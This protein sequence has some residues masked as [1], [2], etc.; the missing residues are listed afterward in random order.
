[1]T[2]QLFLL[3]TM[4]IRVGD[5]ILRPPTPSVGATLAILAHAGGRD[6]SLGELLEG[7]W[8]GN[9]PASA[10]S[11]LRNYVST[12]RRTL[13]A[14]GSAAAVT[15][16]PGGYRFDAAIE[17]DAHRMEQHLADALEHRHAQRVDRAR[18]S[19]DAALACWRGDALL[20]I[21]G[22]WAAAERR[23]LHA[24]RRTLREISA[25]IHLD[26]GDTRTASAELEALVTA[27]PHNERLRALLMTALHRSGRRAAA[28]EVF[29]ATRRL[30]IDEVGMEPGPALT[31][32]HRRLLTEDPRALP[33]LA[34]AARAVETF[35]PPALPEQ[36]AAARPEDSAPPVGPAA[37]TAGSVPFA[38][39]T[40]IGP[41]LVGRTTELEELRTAAARVADTGMSGWVLITGEAGSGKTALART[42]E[43]ALTRENWLPIRVACPEDEG[44]PPAW[45]WAAALRNLV[46]Q[47]HIPDPGVRPALD[48]LLAVD[49]PIWTHPDGS[50]A[51]AP[52][53]GPA[54]GREATR[55]DDPAAGRFRLH[56]A[57][58][59]YLTQ[60]ARQRPLLIV[61]EDRHRADEET[62]LLT[63][64]LAEQFAGVPVLFVMTARP[65]ERTGVGAAA[66]AR[67]ARLEP[68]R[69]QL[70]G[71]ADAE[72]DSLVRAVAGEGVRA[73]SIE[74]IAEK[75]AGNPFFVR[76]WA[77]LL[78]TEGDSAVRVR[79]PAGVREIVLRRI[80]VLPEPVG[81]VL[82]RAAVIGREADTEV[83]ADLIGD[84]DGETVL[85]VVEAGLR[86]GLLEEP[87]AG[88]I[89]FV[90]VLVR[91]ILYAEMAALRRSRLHARVAEIVERRLPGD[92]TALA[93]HYT[94]AATP[95][96][97]RKAAEYCCA[98]AESAEQRF[99]FADAARLWSQAVEAVRRTP[100]N[101]PE[102]AV[103]PVVRH[104]R[105]LAL[106]GRMEEARTHRG[107]ALARFESPLLRARVAAA[108]DIPLVWIDTD[109]AGCDRD[110]LA[111][112]DTLLDQVPENEG[113]LR[114]RL[115]VTAALELA[116]TGEDRGRVLSLAAEALAR[117]L[118][119]PYLLGLALNAKE[120]N[121][122][123]AAGR[124]AVRGADGRELLALA[125][126]NDLAHLRII[127]HT[128]LMR[129]HAG[130]GELSEAVRHATAARELSVRYELPALA[131]AVEICEALALLVAGRAVEAEA[132]YRDW[133]HRLSVTGFWGLGDLIPVLA[134]FCLCWHPDGRSPE[135][136]ALEPEMTELHRRWGGFGWIILGRAAT[137][138]ADGRPDDARAVLADHDPQPTS[139]Y[140]HELQLVLTGAVG[141]S[142]NNRAWVERAYHHLRPGAAEL[143]GAAT[144]TATLGPIALF[145]GR[146]AAYLGDMSSAATHFADALTVAERAEAPHWMAEARSAAADLAPATPVDP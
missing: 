114:C 117:E 11:S 105:A 64:H 76:E 116:N 55:S 50:R 36:S 20:G 38:R 45:P 101:A 104:I 68:L 19:M 82:G 86:A 66:E 69:V 133:G 52:A 70:N 26:S 49:S 74:L 41:R 37:A 113:A 47:G 129:S 57:V 124:A 33:R 112:I 30:L 3:G 14:V 136:A 115:L 8:G 138:I 75:T 92:V 28:L 23:R 6:V 25:E 106:A 13:A 97:A 81:E 9:R 34:G 4:E 132:A 146:F 103:V 61:V 39:P 91:D 140:M 16:I 18:T 108:I 89:R 80:A 109:P 71:L 130:L 84:A 21:P 144:A 90:H 22:P 120:F 5:T 142:L 79:V 56:R 87:A 17:I 65:G 53:S 131:V 127:A 88:R 141:M 95:G 118:H 119:D 32:L 67:L 1:M 139:S 83:L 128:T 43:D 93:H 134:R 102:A 145:L 62:L 85:E 107:A 54:R 27:D 110:L 59:A 2:V 29:R 94:A 122:Y 40:R 137:I 58:D 77:E 51:P 48:P 125:E 12:L 44:A 98:A 123:H 15:S 46:E 7:V 35:T 96:T 126:A 121:S 10:T 143:A 60:L 100:E 42:L 135:L 31:D 78:R 24:T 111:H 99:A 73:E 72:V 63:T